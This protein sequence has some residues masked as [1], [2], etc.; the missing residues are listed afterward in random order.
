M[1]V[2]FCGHKEVYNEEDVRQWLCMVCI[3][4]IAQGASEFYCGGY[5]HFDHMCA[6]T[7]RSLKHQ[8][9]G[10]RIVLVLP[11]LN[12]TM[13]TDGY[14]ETVYPP[15]ESVPKRYAISRRNEWMVRESDIVVAYV[16]RGF[17]GA[18]KTLEFAQ[19]KKKRI[20]AYNPDLS[21]HLSLND[22]WRNL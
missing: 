10:I 13:L 22:S 8:H 19:R 17:G 12:S 14:D 15:L 6:A 21:N 2:T 5:G 4:L 11:Y 18:A 1:R 20:I 16:I 9:P 3:E 7:L